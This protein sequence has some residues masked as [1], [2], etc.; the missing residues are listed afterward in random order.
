M[1]TRGVIAAARG[2]WTIV[3]TPVQVVDLV[4]S[5]LQGQELFRNEY[6]GRLTDQA[7]KAHKPF[8]SRRLAA[9]DGYGASV[10]EV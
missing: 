5:E 10:C 1:R 7:T 6:V 4:I 2:H 9:C 8:A 3:G